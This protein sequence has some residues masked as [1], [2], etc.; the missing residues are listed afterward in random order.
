[1]KLVL[2]AEKMR[3]YSYFSGMTVNPNRPDIN[4]VPS[5]ASPQAG[6][7]VDLRCEVSGA[8]GGYTVNWTRV[9]GAELAEGTITRG[10]MIR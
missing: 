3:C 5:S 2:M 6:D 8:G 4:I 1:M 7:S 9:G 10:D